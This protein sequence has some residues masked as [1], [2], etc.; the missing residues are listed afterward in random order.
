MT[1]SHQYKRFYK[2]F[3]TQKMKINKTMERQ[4]VLNHQRRKDK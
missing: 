1:P 3:C 4:E 2:E